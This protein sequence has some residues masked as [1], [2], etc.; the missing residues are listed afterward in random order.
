MTKISSK[1]IRSSF[2]AIVVAKK[3]FRCS[4]GFLLQPLMPA[5]YVS[6]HISGKWYKYTESTTGHQAIKSTHSSSRP[7]DVVEREPGSIQIY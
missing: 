7:S 2:P 1:A 4:D 3:M 5:F 6:E